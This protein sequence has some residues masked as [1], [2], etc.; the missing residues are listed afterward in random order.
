MKQL[1]PEPVLKHKES[2]QKMVATADAYGEDL[3]NV[4][5][6]ETKMKHFVMNKNY[7]LSKGNKKDEHGNSIRDSP[8]GKENSSDI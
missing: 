4:I 2:M 8:D 1:S 5:S 6:Q 7:E 3:N